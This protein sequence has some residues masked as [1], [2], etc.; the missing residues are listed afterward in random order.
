[1]S[2]DWLDVGECNVYLFG[3]LFSLR[4]L[5][6]LVEVVPVRPLVLVHDAG[7]LVLRL[8]RGLKTGSENGNK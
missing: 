5:L 7:D 6:V 3:F 2:L 1:M 8:D 4:L